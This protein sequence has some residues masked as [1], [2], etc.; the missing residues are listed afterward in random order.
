M[1]SCKLFSH[2]KAMFNCFM[3]CLTIK[4]T[5]SPT[6]ACCLDQMSVHVWNYNKYIPGCRAH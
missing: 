5:Q 4:F 3:Y 1:E 6:Y 2:L